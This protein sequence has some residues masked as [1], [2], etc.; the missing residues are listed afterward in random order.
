MTANY[1]G[2][3]RNE[4][5]DTIA[6]K[7]NV[8]EKDSFIIQLPNERRLGIKRKKEEKRKEAKCD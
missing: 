1:E 3:R 5:V 4:N 2:I 7:K 6:A 8:S